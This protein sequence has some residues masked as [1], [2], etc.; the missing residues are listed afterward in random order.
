MTRS[1]LARHFERRLVQPDYVQLLAL[2]LGIVLFVIATRWV[3]VDARV[4]DAWFGVAPARLIGVALLGL[5]YGSAF[6][7]RPR[8]HQVAALGSVVLAALLSFP[9]ELATYAAGHPS[10]PLWWGVVVPTVDSV[11]YFGLGLVIGRIST[12]TRLRSI[13]PLTVP[14][15]LVGVTWLDIHL[16]IAVLNPLTS[17]TTVAPWHLALA[18]AGAAATLFVLLRPQDGASVE[19]EP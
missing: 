2:Y 15:L 19:V 6:S 11:A 18:T 3:G 14:A 10:V 4:N 8:V 1:E 5:G 7:E 9:L 17:A 12:W 13:L 16:R